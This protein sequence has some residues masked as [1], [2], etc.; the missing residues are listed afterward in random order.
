MEFL[1]VLF[2]NGAITWEQFVQGVATK[3][4]K[5]GDLS[6]GEYVDKRKHND[7]LADKDNV[8]NKLNACN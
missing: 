2:E 1:K 8:I 4:L 5:I 3:G 6:S 7:T